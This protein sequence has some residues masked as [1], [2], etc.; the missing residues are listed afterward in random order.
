MGIWGKN[1]FAKSYEMGEELGKG[2][3]ATVKKCREKSTGKDYAVKIMTIT[4][5][6]EYGHIKKEI[7]ILEKLHH[8]HV[9]EMKEIFE[10]K[11][12][13]GK[14]MVYIVMELVTGGELFTKIVEKKNFSEAE[15]RDVTK[16]ILE[17]LVYA[18]SVG[19]A[20]RDLKPENILLKEQGSMEVKITDWGLS[21]LYIPQDNK[22]TVQLMQTMCGTPGYVAPEVLMR[23]G[24]GFS[25]DVWS[26]GI[27]LYVMLCGYLPFQSS[28]RNRLFKRIKRG[29]YKMASPYWDDIS[30]NAKDLVKQMLVVNP[31]AR[32]TA[33]EALKHPWFAASKPTA[34][35]NTQMHANF[36][37]YMHAK[38]KW[39]H[40]IH[41]MMALN[42]LRHEMEK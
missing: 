37:N 4:D 6:I 25:C 14:N 7:E 12:M 23:N 17:T 5:D 27:I 21:K 34:Q 9:V 35:I 24:Y 20:H 11:S 3:F 16:T 33:A 26:A 1:E 38:K 36:N 29:E 32:V 2:N 41:T 39:N 18:Q 13:R 8:P 30:E 40:Y 42:R 15:A 31:T 19:I 10:T 22:K 28:D